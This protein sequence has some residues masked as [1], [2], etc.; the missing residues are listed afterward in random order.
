MSSFLGKHVFPLIRKGQL[1][2]NLHGNKKRS[3]GV[4][5]KYFKKIFAVCNRKH[6]Y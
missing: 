1:K 4:Y 5:L 6:Q 3:H 2:Y